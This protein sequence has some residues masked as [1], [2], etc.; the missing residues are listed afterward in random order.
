MEQAYLKS[1]L[2]YAPRRGV[3]YWISPPGA[4]SELLGEEAGTFPKSGNKIYCYITIDGVKYKRGRL[5]FLYMTGTMP[6]SC[7]DH[8]NGIST[9]DRWCN[10]RA[11]SVLQNN[12]NH[13]RRSKASDL[14]MGVR[15]T[16]SGRFAARIGVHGKQISLGSFDTIEAASAAYQ[17][18]RSKYFGQFA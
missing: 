14:P 8:I 2:L 17:Q 11:A 1:R 15:S 9:D 7:I 6:P 5:A 13:K 4:H 3:F 12:W 10:L 16:K 18:A